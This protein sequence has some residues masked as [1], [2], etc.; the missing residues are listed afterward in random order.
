MLQQQRS[1]LTHANV[2][3]RSLRWKQL[4]LEAI[5]M[6]V[7][8]TG[9]DSKLTETHEACPLASV[10]ITTGVLGMVC[11]VAVCHM[12]LC[13]AVRATYRRK[14]KDAPQF[15]TGVL[16]GATKEAAVAVVVLPGVH[17]AVLSSTSCLAAHI[18]RAT[19][20]SLEAMVQFFMCQPKRRNGANS[21]KTKQARYPKASTFTRLA[22]QH[23]HIEAMVPGCCGNTRR[24]KML[25]PNKV[26]LEKQSLQI[27]QGLPWN[28]R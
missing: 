3:A 2:Q 20:L 14:D 18:L 28:T 17:L 13:A 5:K 8:S 4:V 11:T 10:W 1:V 7:A 21:M 16:A 26:G 12:S 25:Q 19:E 22:Q 23:H 24:P 15:A 27:K 6:A 9:S